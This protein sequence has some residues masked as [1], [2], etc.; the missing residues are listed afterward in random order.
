[1]DEK[2]ISEKDR[3]KLLLAVYEQHW[4]HARHCENERLW[5]TNIY[6][7][8][9]AGALSLFGGSVYSAFGVAVLL[10]LMSLTVLGL[11]LSLKI[12]LI[13]LW[14][15]DR[16][17]EIV[18]RAGLEDYLI[19]VTRPKTRV[20]KISASTLFVLFY[21]VCFSILCS[22]LVFTLTEQTLLTI[23]VF[24]ASSLVL[25]GCIFY[26]V[27]PLFNFLREKQRKSVE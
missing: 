21:V 10:S 23:L 25:T 22:L 17:D 9:L 13:F 7:V 4:L 27:K 8:I 24:A 16:A 19:D 14:H 26:S 18:R 11:L 5:F 2:G 6:A 12:K 1:M 15:T 3:F 20:Q